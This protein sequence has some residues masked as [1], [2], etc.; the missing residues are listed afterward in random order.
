MK[1]EKYLRVT[2]TD[3]TQWDIPAEYIAKLR[4]TY[5]AKNAAVKEGA[6]YTTYIAVYDEEFA[7][8]MDSDDELI[9][10][11]SNNMN[12]SDVCIYAQRV[13]TIPPKQP[14]YQDGWVNGDK[15]IVLK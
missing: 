13:I 14:D 3:Q 10:W 11:A 12:W 7:H 5:Y 4:A 1:K 15:E 8:T 6:D 2:M 9:D